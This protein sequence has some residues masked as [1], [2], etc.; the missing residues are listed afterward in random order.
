VYDTPR[1][2]EQILSMLAEAPR[3]LADLSGGLPPA[4]LLTPPEP[5]EWSARDVL[6][7]LR[8][9][10][11]M[12]GKYMA[13]MLSE[14]K[15]TFKAVNPT[16]WIKQTNYREQ[17]FQPSLQAFTAQRADLLA[18]LKPLAPEAWTRTAMVMGAGKPRERNVYSYA[19]WL[20]NHERSHIKQ[21]ERIANALRG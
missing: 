19:L 21:I 2:I 17:E 13:V 4:H 14:D 6:A 5:G 18:M 15:P 7:H 1:S 16:T 8:A 11:D 20:A 10:A 9:C 3:H 12:W